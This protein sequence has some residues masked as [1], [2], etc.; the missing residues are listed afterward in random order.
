LDKKRK[1]KTMKEENDNL[2][3]SPISILRGHT[4]EVTTV[5][6]FDENLISG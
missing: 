6:F 2:P 5:K 1:L 3:I 4:S